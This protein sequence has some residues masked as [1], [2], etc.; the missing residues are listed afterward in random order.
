MDFNIGIAHFYHDN[1][2]DND[3][4]WKVFSSYISIDEENWQLISN[5]L[6]LSLFSKI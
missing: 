3:R 6:A 4:Y 5:N 1:T 2:I